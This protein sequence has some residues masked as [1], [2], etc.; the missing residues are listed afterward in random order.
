[1]S[2]K[3]L[4]VYPNY[5]GMNMLPPAIGLM[6]AIL[7]NNGHTVRL[8]DTTYYEN[9]DGSNIDSDASKTERLMARPFNMPKEKVT[10]MTTDVY[11][12]FEKEVNS[13]QPELLALSATEDMF[14][15][16][17]K[18]L[19]RV[20]EYNILTIAGG[21]FATFAPEL[22]LSYPEVDIVCRGE[23][24]ETIRLLCERLSKGKHYNDLPNLFIK[25]KDGSIRR[26]PL[27]MI[28]MDNNPL[29]DMSLFEEARYYRPMGGKVWRMFPVETHRGCP[30]KCN[31]CNSPVQR[32]MYKE[33]TGNSF[34]RRKSFQNIR[35][36]L[37]YY[38]N[39]MKAEYLYFWADTFFSW[40]SRE[41]DEFCEI[42]EDIRLPF[43]CQTRP[44]TVEIKKFKKLKDIGCAR[45]A[46]GLEHGN[47][48]FRRKKLN[49]RVSNKVIIENLRIV[50]NVGIPI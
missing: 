43:W 9:I 33:E 17:I 3:V 1:M 41:F 13:F 34:L 39:V 27:Q 7:K 10:L 35:K 19:K 30:F 21:V 47:E 32:S 14:P 37:L 5:R 4:F 31:Y 6:S 28:D 8:F 29:I 18:L 15:L 22:V 45:I 2:I 38:K 25:N 48:E 44:E 11:E 26:N 12:D 23:G 46:F 40:T 49:R 20:Q 36:E 24:E 42:Y 16:G 50:N